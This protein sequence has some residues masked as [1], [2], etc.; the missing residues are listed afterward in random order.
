MQMPT[1][2]SRSSPLPEQ[3]FPSSP[4]SRS[5]C[6]PRKDKLS[7]ITEDLEFSCAMLNC[8]RLDMKLIAMETLL[9]L[10]SSADSDCRSCA[11]Q[12]VL[13]GPIFDILVENILCENTICE[14]T[15]SE[16][17][18]RCDLM[19]KIRRNALSVFSNCLDAVEKGCAVIEEKESIICDELLTRL[20]NDLVDSST[21]PHE[22][23]NAAKCL[24]KLFQS[25]AK[26]MDIGSNDLNADVISACNGVTRQDH[27]MLSQ[28]LVQLE[29]L[30]TKG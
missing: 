25:S 27:A 17:A 20:L 24:R 10:T 29:Q 5:F 28:E 11:S 15:A 8:N 26:A 21:N 18:V 2:S 7:A 16:E 19:C 4:V 14:V 3:P 9:K 1:A 6:P 23:F 22:A 12:G 30:I 13:S